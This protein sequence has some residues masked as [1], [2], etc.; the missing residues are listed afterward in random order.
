MEE[1]FQ[2]R[3]AHGMNTLQPVVAGRQVGT[4]VRCWL[5]A[6]IHFL[7]HPLLQHRMRDGKKAGHMFQ[8]P[9]ALCMIHPQPVLADGPVGTAVLGNACLL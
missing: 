5:A 1:L 3:W 7:E 2:W 9:D 4:S 8:L 6:F